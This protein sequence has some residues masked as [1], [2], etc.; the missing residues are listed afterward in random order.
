MKKLG[1]LVKETSENK[2]KASL[3]ES[4]SV[5]ILNYS[6][7]SSPDLS[8]L[9][10]SLKNSQARLLVVK[11]TVARRA[12]KDSDLAELLKTI[13]GPCGLVFAKEEPVGVSRILCDFSKTHEQLK[14]EGGA[15]KNRIIGKTDI[16]ALAKLPSKEILRAQVV[17]TLNS[18]LSGIVSVLNQTIRKFVYCIEQ[19]KNK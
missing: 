14:L 15:L 3:K 16:E 6:K 2:I 11:N 13:E 12:L 9:R 18:P 4:D 17:M 8:A 1:L 5:F 10:R 7:V 19:I